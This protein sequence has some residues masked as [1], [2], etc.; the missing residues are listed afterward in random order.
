MAELI[1][2]KLSFTELPTNDCRTLAFA[3]TSIYGSE[4]E[5]A[6]L[7][8]QLPDKESI[9]E[10]TYKAGG[11]TILNSNT[12][13][14]SKVRSQNELLDLP[15]GV[16][17]LKISVCPYDMYWYEKDLYRICKLQC[18]YNKALLG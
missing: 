8:V 13:K 3:D 17:T 4:A 7:Q 10:L 16:Y 18:K 5:G 11:V 14:Y 12:L 6:T 2:T 1:Y 9:I 15:D